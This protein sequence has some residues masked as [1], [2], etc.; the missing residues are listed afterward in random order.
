M[1]K[2][3][4]IAASF[5]AALCTL[6]SCNKEQSSFSIEDVPGKAQITGSL[7]I[8][9]GKSYVNGTLVDRMAPAANMEVIARL[10]N[11]DFISGASG[12]T[13]YKTMTNINGEYSIKIPVLDKGVSVTVTVA[14]ILGV[15]SEFVNQSGSQAQLQDVRGVFSFSK[16]IS[17]VK[18]GNIKIVNGEFNF[19]AED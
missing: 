12:Y 7:Y 17:G 5:L 3:I 18:P 2:I 11:N 16:N 15:R 4:F 8:N 9:Y 10:S 1:K 19:K 14:D 13:D 6:P